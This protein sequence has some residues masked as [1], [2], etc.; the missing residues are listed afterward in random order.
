MLR[1]DIVHSSDS[2]KP[3]TPALVARMVRGWKTFVSP[4]TPPYVF[5]CSPDDPFLDYIHLL[6]AGMSTALAMA[7]RDQATTISSHMSHV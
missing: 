7:G 2:D 3:V 5:S 4:N 6:L 1:K